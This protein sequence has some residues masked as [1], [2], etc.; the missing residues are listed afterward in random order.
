MLMQLWFLSVFG[1]CDLGQLAPKFFKFVRLGVVLTMS[2][3]SLNHV[4]KIGEHTN[5]CIL[6]LSPSARTLARWCGQGHK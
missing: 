4:I 5:G 6:T 1:N 2:R 3:H